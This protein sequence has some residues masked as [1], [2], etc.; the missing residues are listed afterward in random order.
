MIASRT[1]EPYCSGLRKVMEIMDLNHGL[2]FSF[3][4]KQEMGR[5]IERI[6]TGKTEKEVF[7]NFAESGGYSDNIMQ[8]KTLNKRKT[9][10]ESII[11]RQEE[12]MES[13]SKVVMSM[14]LIGGLFLTIALL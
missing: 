3:V 7:L 5:S 14:G 11:N 2:T 12:K 4:W 10:L 1:E 13:K 9:E 6:V 8:L